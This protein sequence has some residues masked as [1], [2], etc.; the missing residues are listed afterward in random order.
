MNS[1]HRYGNDRKK[2]RQTLAE[3]Q[4]Q[5]AS[6]N[7][8]MEQGQ[9]ELFALL[10]RRADI[11]AK[12]RRSDTMVEQ[13]N[14]RKA[15]LG[16]RLLDRKTQ[17]TDLDSVLADCKKDLEEVSAHIGEL[18]EQEKELSAKEKEWRTKAKGK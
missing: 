17:E 2:Q 1:L 6:C 3:I 10:N 12:Q 7:E 13:I 4:K 14:I 18:S 11:Q 16:K 15:E 5:I 9:K 8:G